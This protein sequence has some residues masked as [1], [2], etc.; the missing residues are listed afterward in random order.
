MNGS[1]NCALVEY[2]L[3]EQIGSLVKLLI[4]RMASDCRAFLHNSVLISLLCRMIREKGVE[5][6]T[7][8]LHN[9]PAIFCVKGR[10]IC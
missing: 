8:Y 10:K 6:A 5:T 2:L 9:Y 1:F 4:C 7:Y 3:I